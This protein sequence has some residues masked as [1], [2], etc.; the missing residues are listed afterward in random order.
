MLL[1]HRILP[2]SS[3]KLEAAFIAGLIGAKMP[4]KEEFDR[5]VAAKMEE[6]ISSRPLR[7]GSWDAGIVE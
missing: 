3:E 7:V 2:T 5:I 6:V 4:S 1:R